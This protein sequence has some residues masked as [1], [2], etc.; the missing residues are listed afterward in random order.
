MNF[1]KRKFATEFHL[2][3]T[4][5]FENSQK[6][7]ESN[8]D[9]TQYDQVLIPTNDGRLIQGFLFV[10]EGNPVIIPEPDPSILYLTNAEREILPLL[11]LK[12]YFPNAPIASQS[13]ETA[14]KFFDFFQHAMNFTIN[15]CAS[16]EAFHNSVIPHDFK[17]KHKSRYLNKI[18]IQK[19]INFGEKAKKI[20]PAIYNRSYVKDFGSKYEQLLY[21]KSLRDGVIHTKDYSAKGQSVSFR[22]L[23]KDF[24]NFNFENALLLTKEYMNYYEPEHI[25]N[26]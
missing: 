18:E 15:L 16:I 1:T 4:E 8:L 19:A 24:L 9:L 17:H 14:N 5:F 13:A 3:A 11:K 25:E 21:L 23:Y 26:G 10:S 22:E 20:L 7:I 12:K 2:D 6:H